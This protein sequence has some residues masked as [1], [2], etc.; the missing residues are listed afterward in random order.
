MAKYTLTVKNSVFAGAQVTRK[1]LAQ[2]IIQE[3]CYPHENIDYYTNNL[4]NLPLDEYSEE[5]KNMER[6]CRRRRR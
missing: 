3:L 6:P 1:E 2:T 4:G 5:L